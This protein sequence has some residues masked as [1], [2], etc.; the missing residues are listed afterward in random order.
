VAKMSRSFFKKIKENGK[1]MAQNFLSPI[2]FRFALQRAPNIEYY[3]QAASI[4]SLTAGFATVY[5][6]FSNLSFSPDK[7][8]Y[9]DFSITFRVDE[10]M[11]NYLELHNWLIGITFP[12]NFTQHNNL[13][14][15][16]QGDNS[17][18]FSDATLTILNS[19]KNANVEVQFEDLFP[20][21]ISDIQ[22]DVRASDINYSEATAT[23][24]YKRFT[25]SVI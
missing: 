11:S 8:E 10:D 22:L 5:T 13:V 1:N 21:T 17:G 25:V 12:D 14:T 9:G 18:I 16:E 23:F 19:T 4:P 2:G 20:T 15:R 24:R 6:P 3:I 7:L